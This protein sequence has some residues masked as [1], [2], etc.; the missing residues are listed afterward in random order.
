MYLDIRC[1]G[2]KA[3]ILNSSREECQFINSLEVVTVYLIKTFFFFLQNLRFKTVNYV[4]ELRD[5]LIPNTSENI[6]II[7]ETQGKETNRFTEIFPKSKFSVF[8]FVS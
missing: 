6:L 3:L 7:R 8:D 5:K 2:T 1:N 4:L